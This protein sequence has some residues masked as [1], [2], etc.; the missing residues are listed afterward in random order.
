MKR[1]CINRSTGK[2]I[3]MQSDGDDNPELMEGRLNTL[4]QNAINCGYKEDEIE[5][6]W[7][8]AEEVASLTAPDPSEVERAHVLSELQELDKQ[9]IRSI[10]EWISSHHDSPDRL[11]DLEN[12]AQLARAKLQGK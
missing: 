7:A 12:K 3:E 6:K 9:S 5:V 11:L 4:R 2:L 8:D 10:R 1:V